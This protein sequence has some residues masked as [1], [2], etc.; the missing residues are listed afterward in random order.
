MIQTKEELSVSSNLQ[1]DNLI[2]E[3][4]PMGDVGTEFTYM[5]KS[6]GSHYVDGFLTHEGEE[7]ASVKGTYKSEG[8]GYLDAE[9]CMEKLPLCFVNFL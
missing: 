8:T 5:P 6:D 9:V 1:I 4:C 7:V 3:K 2:Y